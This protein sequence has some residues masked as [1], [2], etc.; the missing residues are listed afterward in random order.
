[1]KK[2]LLVLSAVLL[3]SAIYAAGPGDAMSVL[4]AFIAT[5]AKDT[6]AWKT[7]AVAIADPSNVAPGRQLGYSTVVGYY[8]FVPKRFDELS[9]MEKA[10]VYADP[11]LKPFL[12]SLRN[13]NNYPTVTGT[14]IPKPAM[15]VYP[16]EGP[17]APQQQAYYYPQQA[18]SGYGYP[19][20]YYYP[21]QPQ[22]T[23]AAQPYTQPYYTTAAL[24][25]A[26]VLAQPVTYAM[27]QQP[28]VSRLRVSPEE[29]L[30]DRPLKIYM[31]NQ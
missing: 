2:H 6:P 29:I 12:V 18:M 28:Q 9:D 25:P 24:A 19:A 5:F 15:P 7:D 14:D 16:V 17:Y 4:N 31:Q 23:Y 22:P 3:A 21:Q 8:T 26:N 1:M 30:L 11:R 20:A 13:Y 27:P 10:D